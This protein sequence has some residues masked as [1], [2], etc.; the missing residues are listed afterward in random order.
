MTVKKALIIAAAAAAAGGIVY[1]NNLDVDYSAAVNNRS[2][3]SDDNSSETRSI[4]HDGILGG[5]HSYEL[6]HTDF[7]G[8][9]IVF[10]VVPSKQLT[11]DDF[12][13]IYYNVSSL[14]PK[15][16]PDEFGANR[17]LKNDDYLGDIKVER[18]GNRVIVVLSLYDVSDEQYGNGIK[19]VLTA[20]DGIDFIQRVFVTDI[21]SYEND[22]Y[23]DYYD[24]YY[25]YA[26]SYS[27]EDF[28][29]YFKEY[30]GLNSLDIGYEVDV[31]GF[32][33]E[34]F[35]FNV[36]FGGDVTEKNFNDADNAIGK[37]FTENETDDRY[38]GYVDVS[39]E[40][41]YISIYLD[42]GNVEPEDCNFV[43]Q[44]IIKALDSVE[45]VERAVINE[46]SGFY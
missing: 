36:Y 2:I 18:A 13:I 38:L 11:D 20:L 25:D 17:F 4:D 32:D 46:D 35:S 41:E 3:I 15:P 39:N 5:E 1:A 7:S 24:E 44:G 40:T 8:D 42:L 34:C 26:G 23:D 31:E 14:F 30:M 22:Y 21:Y 19:S 28:K 16:D 33:G 12:E 10:E 43:V 9:L 37:F 6:E 27:A 45:G 29:D